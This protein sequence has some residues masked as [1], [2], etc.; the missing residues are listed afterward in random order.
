MAKGV[1]ITEEDVFKCIQSNFFPWHKYYREEFEKTQI[2]LHHTVSGKGVA[3]DISWM[4]RSFYR[5]ATAFIIDRNGLIWQ[6]FNSSY[7]AKHLGVKESVMKGL[8]NCD[9]TA[10]DLN[11]HSIGIELDSWG[12][13][14]SFEGRF[15]PVDKAGFADYRNKKAVNPDYV[16]RK[17]HRGFA[18]YEQY[19]PMQIKSLRYLL[20][21][22][23]EVYGIS[24]E[25]YEGM[26]EYSLYALKGKNG[27]WSHTAYRKDKSDACPQPKLVEMLQGLKYDKLIA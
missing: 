24:T 15:Y 6:Q 12:P 10:N 8:S 25:Y 16:C 23:T 4:L 18:F 1:S 5:I 20:I 3:G 17:S 14:A 22:L 26:F 27:I 13:L 9:L 21:Y 11:R 19:T 7:W 2:A